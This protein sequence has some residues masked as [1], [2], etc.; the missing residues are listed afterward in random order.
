MR[1]TR[2]G[3]YAIRCIYYLARQGE[4][5]VTKRQQISHT[6]SIPDQFLGKIAQQLSQAGLI[7]IV[8]GSKGGLRLVIS[9]NKISMLDVIEAVIGKIFLNDCILRKESCNRSTACIAHQVW[10]KARD[11]L[12]DTLAE[13]TFDKLVHEEKYFRPLCQF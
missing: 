3:E 13:A 9:P 2:A 6:M 8:Q 10:Q 11:Q 5:V 4:G 7:E 1:L 12:R